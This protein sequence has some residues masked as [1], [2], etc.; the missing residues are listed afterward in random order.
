MP[1]KEQVQISVTETDDGFRVEVTGKSLK[2]VFSGCCIP[3]VAACK[4]SSGKCCESDK[5]QKKD[6]A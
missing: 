2:E 4:D 5:E 6:K 1:D 3:I